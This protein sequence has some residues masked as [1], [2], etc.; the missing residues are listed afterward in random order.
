MNGPP[1]LLTKPNEFDLILGLASPT[2]SD[3]FS[4]QVVLLRLLGYVVSVPE[5]EFKAAAPGQLVAVSPREFQQ[6]LS[7]TQETAFLCIELAF[8]HWI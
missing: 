4:P 5:V 1:E 3:L 2:G 7:S 8:S 6:I